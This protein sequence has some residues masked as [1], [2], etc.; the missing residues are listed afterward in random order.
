MCGP[1]SLL[2]AGWALA[3]C[4][5]PTKMIATVAT[6]RK[7]IAFLPSPYIDE[8]LVNPVSSRDA[9]TRGFRTSSLSALLR[10]VNQIQF[11]LHPK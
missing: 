11:S 7:V 4:H 2:F 1:L 6:I 10:P 3:A 5:E 9:Y 8:L